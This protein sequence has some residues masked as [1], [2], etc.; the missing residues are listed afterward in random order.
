[1]RHDFL[2][3]KLRNSDLHDWEELLEREGILREDILTDPD[4]R[5]LWIDGRY[6]RCEVLAFVFDGLPPPPTLDLAAQWCQEHDMEPQWMLASSNPQWVQWGTMLA[7]PDQDFNFVHRHWLIDAHTWSPSKFQVILGHPNWRKSLAQWDPHHLF[8]KNPLPSSTYEVVQL[9]IDHQALNEKALP[10]ALE[11]SLIHANDK[12][13][14]MVHPC[15]APNIWNT[16]MNFDWLND[17][18]VADANKSACFLLEAAPQHP[19]W[20]WDEVVKKLS[21]AHTAHITNIARIGAPTLGPLH[22]Y[23]IAQVVGQL[24]AHDCIAPAVALRAIFPAFISSARVPTQSCQEWL[25]TYLTDDQQQ[26]MFDEV[27]PKMLAFFPEHH[28][29]KLHAIF[30]RQA[31]RKHV[32]M[33]GQSS[34]VRK[35]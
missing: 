25:H 14:S 1:M 23:P 19:Q 34:K 11:S 15:A 3:H 32:E 29:P 24:V 27:L 22:H 17:Y 33:D 8:L 16:L 5:T 20:D 9:L 35:I 26:Q 7:A 28:H 13:F 2:V 12:L 21:S 30:E 31:L 10:W 4:L 6:V 18:V